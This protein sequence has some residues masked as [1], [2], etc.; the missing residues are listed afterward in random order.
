MNPTPD[1]VSKEFTSLS[2][3]DRL[4]LLLEYSDNLPDLPSRYADSPELL[5]KV[6][7]C[8]SP[9]YLFVEVQDEK[10]SVFITAPEEAPTTRGFAGILHELLNGQT[11]QSVLNLSDD[12]PNTLGLA[13]AIS[14]LRMR[15]MRAMLYRIKR[16]V[17]E[18]SHS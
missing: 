18:K 13:E 7:E 9:V 10:V 14:P 4:Q 2:V 8:Q 3:K 12:F 17:T 16:Q 11:T 15:G 1:E 6:E 5:E